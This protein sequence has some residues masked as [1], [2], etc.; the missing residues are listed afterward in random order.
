MIIVTNRLYV[1]VVYS[2]QTVSNQQSVGQ[3]VDDFTQVIA[4]EIDSHDGKTL[5]FASE[6]MELV[7]NALNLCCF[8]VHFWEKLILRKLYPGMEILEC[9]EWIEIW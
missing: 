7:C 1:F 8:S 2:F 3:S 4:T 6:R 5:C 9:Y